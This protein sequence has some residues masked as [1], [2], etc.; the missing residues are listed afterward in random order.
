MSRFGRR[1]E[2]DLTRIADRATPSST[3]WDVIRQRIEVS[4]HEPETEIIMLSPERNRPSRRPRTW[5]LA[6]AAALV[7]VL[8]IGLVVV[9]QLDDDDEPATTDVPPPSPAAEYRA[10]VWASA[11]D[12]AR[13]N[14]SEERPVLSDGPLDARMNMFV[15]TPGP[16]E[17]EFCAEAVD[18]GAT[19]PGGEVRTLPE[20]SSCMIVEWE[21]EIGDESPRNGGMDARDAVTADG[22]TVEPLV[23]DIPTTPPGGSSSVTVVYPNLGP[24]S[25]VSI[26]YEVYQP[27]GK[28]VFERWEVVVPDAFEPIDWFEDPS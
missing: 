25:E 27:D 5:L 22:E 16:E 21:Y 23:Y 13:V 17:S 15:I 11:D 4:P 1:L 19:G 24:G 2:R 10:V 9:P 14:M 26:G 7:T 3:G 12:P 8:A 6:G 18:E 28:I 20:V